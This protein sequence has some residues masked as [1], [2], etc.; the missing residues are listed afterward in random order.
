MPTKEEF[1]VFLKHYMKLSGTDASRSISHPHLSAYTTE[2]RATF[3]IPEC[4][5]VYN[6]LRIQADEVV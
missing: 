4:V 3:P 2:E 1:A 6:W 5:K